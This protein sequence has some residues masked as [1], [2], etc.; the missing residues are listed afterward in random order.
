VHC[1][2]AGMTASGKTTLAKALAAQYRRHRV[3]VAVLDPLNDPG[4]NADFQTTDRREFLERV[5]RSRSC[6][7][8][9]D[10]SGETIGQYNDDMFWL[11][12]RAR[13]YGHRS[14]F[15]TQRPAQLSPTVRHQCLRLF[16]FRVGFKDAKTLAEEFSN[17]DLVGA[18][19]LPQYTFYSINR[20]GPTERLALVL[21]RAN[22][23]SNLNATLPVAAPAPGGRGLPAHEE[24]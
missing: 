11:A 9:I 1:L 5:K 16:C 21:D 20:F 12:T 14:H 13:H 6:A 23:R 8:F 7:L 3:S 24:R 17:P 18:S 10:E 22:K 15:L 2:I 4:W 19:S